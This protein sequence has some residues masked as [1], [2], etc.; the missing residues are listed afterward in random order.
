MRRWAIAR[1]A[2]GISGLIFVGAAGIAVANQ[3]LPTAATGSVI[4]ACAKKMGEVRIVDS[5]ADCKRDET[6]LTWN[7]Q[8]PKGDPGANG[9]DGQSVVLSDAGT[10]CAN[11]GIAA[12][13][14]GI[15]KYVCN[16]APGAA[17]ATG[18]TG[19]PGPPGASGSGSLAGAPCT[20]PEG[21]TGT[22]VLNVAAV[23]HV[24]TLTCVN[25]GAATT[26]TTVQTTTTGPM[27]VVPPPSHH[28][29]YGCDG[30]GNVIVVSCDPGY[31]N[32]YGDMHSLPSFDLTTVGCPLDPNEPN[33]TQGTA[34]PVAFPAVGSTASTGSNYVSGTD[35]DWYTFTAT[36][37]P[38][39]VCAVGFSVSIDA[40]PGSGTNIG[41]T[42]DLYRDGVLVAG[43]NDFS[44]PPIPTVDAPGTC[45]TYLLHASYMGFM[46]FWSVT[47]TNDGS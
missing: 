34:T 31:V 14:G 13:V 19:P 36:P 39:G 6:P 30:N 8:G 3:I 20:R 22:I 11:G 26:T 7:V 47:I 40:A 23:S 37:G 17:G 24:V 18:A 38:T 42:V 28:A 44:Q 25:N 15:T 32:F 29:T 46:S 12:T 45:S 2:L 5:A 35:D 43:A 27:C 21:D 33:N 41:A 9:A 1:R 10:R 4:H 16:G